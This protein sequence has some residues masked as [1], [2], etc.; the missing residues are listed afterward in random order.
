[1]PLLSAQ[2]QTADLE[3]N[4]KRRCQLTRIP[5]RFALPPLLVFVARA[6]ARG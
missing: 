6:R 5:P 1:M 3:Q 2:L 4:D